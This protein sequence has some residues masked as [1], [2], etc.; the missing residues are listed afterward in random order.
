MFQYDNTHWM[1]GIFFYKD[2]ARSCAALTCELV[3]DRTTLH[4][5]V[6]HAYSDWLTAE[7]IVATLLL[8]TTLPVEIQLAVQSILGKI[9]RAGLMVGPLLGEYD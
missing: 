1:G 9:G 6:D 2:V 5:T 7:D 3:P 8:D 4:H